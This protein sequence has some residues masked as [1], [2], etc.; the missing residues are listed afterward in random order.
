MLTILFFSRKDGS[1]V[2][3]AALRDFAR[4]ILK[5]RTGE[6]L[7]FLNIVALLT[8]FPSQHLYL[9]NLICRSRVAISSPP[10]A[11]FERTDF[12]VP[13][14]RHHPFTRNRPSATS[15]IIL[16]FRSSSRL[17]ASA[18]RTVLMILTSPPRRSGT[19]ARGKSFFVLQLPPK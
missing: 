12:T 10:H 1:S 2:Q 15:P 6:S 19:P 3:A 13:L 8:C 4:K 17:L 5:M 11:T 14:A 7:L 16:L 9:R 18:T